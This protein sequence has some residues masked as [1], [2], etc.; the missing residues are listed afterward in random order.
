MMTG[1][2]SARLEAI[3]IIE[4]KDTPGDRANA[5]STMVTTSAAGWVQSRTSG[6]SRVRFGDS[7]RPWWVPAQFRCALGLRAKVGN[8]AT[9]DFVIGSVPTVESHDFEADRG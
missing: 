8:S 9:G 6:A 5:C 1:E 2:E 4:A 3:P 7:H